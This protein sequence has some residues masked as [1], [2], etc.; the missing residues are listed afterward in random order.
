MCHWPGVGTGSPCAQ[1][2]RGTERDTEVTLP[3]SSI[4]SENGTPWPRE[5]CVP[6]QEDTNILRCSFMR[7]CQ[8]WNCLVFVYLPFRVFRFGWVFVCYCLFSLYF[9]GCWCLTICAWTWPASPLWFSGFLWRAEC[10]F[11]AQSCSQMEEVALADNAALIS[12]EL[13]WGKSKMFVCRVSIS[14]FPVGVLAGC[15]KC[16]VIS[17]ETN[18]CTEIGSLFLCFPSYCL[19]S[20]LLYGTTVS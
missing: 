5:Q 20:Y 15:R 13:R 10:I 6:V 8:A 19:L 11:W 12:G 17:C 4:P 14:F 7:R 18:N 16:R 2:E 9:S 3:T 1:K